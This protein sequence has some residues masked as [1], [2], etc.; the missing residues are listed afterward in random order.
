MMNVLMWKCDENSNFGT[1]WKCN[2]HSLIVVRTMTKWWR[3][4][5]DNE[6]IGM[7]IIMSREPLLMTPSFVLFFHWCCC[8]PC[9]FAWNASNNYIVWKDYS[10]FSIYNFSCSTTPLQSSLFLPL[11][12]CQLCCTCHCLAISW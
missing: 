2:K 10:I 8:Y 11:F 12:H 9:H 6:N 3:W 7:T 5:K 1:T 4:W